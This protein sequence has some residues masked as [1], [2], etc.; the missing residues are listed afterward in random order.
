MLFSTYRSFGARGFCCPSGRE[1]WNNELS[2]GELPCPGFTCF[3]PIPACQQGLAVPRVQSSTSLSR[4]LL[5]VSCFSWEGEM[6]MDTNDCQVLIHFKL[7]YLLGRGCTINSGAVWK[8][9]KLLF[10]LL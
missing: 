4:L 6:N 5:S 9:L 10:N 1:R 3:N 7:I 8:E 2:V